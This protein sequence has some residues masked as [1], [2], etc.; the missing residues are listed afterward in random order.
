M[1]SLRL[2]RL[3]ARSRDLSSVCGAGTESPSEEDG[4]EDTAK[5]AFS[6][7]PGFFA[8]DHSLPDLNGCESPPS[9]SS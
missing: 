7:Q 1:H 9:P 5:A 3:S 4:S 6:L 2:A 8:R